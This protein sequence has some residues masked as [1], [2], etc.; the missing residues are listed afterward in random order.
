[1]PD[2]YAKE[3]HGRRTSGTITDIGNSNVGGPYRMDKLPRLLNPVL[4]PAPQ[5]EHTCCLGTV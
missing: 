4:T 5:L 1:M 3:R 2:L